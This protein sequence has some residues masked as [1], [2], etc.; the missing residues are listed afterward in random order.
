MALCQVAKKLE[1][2]EKLMVNK[3]LATIATYHLP[4]KNAI[5][6]LNILAIPPFNF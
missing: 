2:K 4:R 6:L 5:Y 1:R 3:L